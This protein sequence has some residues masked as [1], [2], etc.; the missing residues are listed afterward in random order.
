[1]RDIAACAAGCC[2]V[3]VNSM[4]CFIIDK[5]IAA[6]KRLVVMRRGQRADGGTVQT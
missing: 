6:E 3:N 2:R 1:M 4:C 5:Q